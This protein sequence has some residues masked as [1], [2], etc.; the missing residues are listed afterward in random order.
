MIRNARPVMEALNV[1]EIEKIGAA[2]S[3]LAVAIKAIADII[4]RIEERLTM[5]SIK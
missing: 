5:T 1:W 4:A 2:S 3:I